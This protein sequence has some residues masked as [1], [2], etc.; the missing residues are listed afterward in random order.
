ML[1]DLFHNLF[2]GF[3]IY[4]AVLFGFI[5][6][7]CLIFWKRTRFWL[8]KRA[9]VL[10]AIGLAVGLWSTAHAA[11]DSTVARMS[12]TVKFLFALILPSTVYFFFVAYGGQFFA[13]KGRFKKKAHCPHC[14]LPVNYIPTGSDTIEFA[15]VSCPH[16]GQL[17]S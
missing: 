6:T 12:P 13:F 5:A 16:C 17:L 1:R 11:G 7:T 14:K 4:H 2:R 9:H 3:R 15:S 10:A 8:P